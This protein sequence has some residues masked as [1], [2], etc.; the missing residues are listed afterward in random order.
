MI[1]FPNVSNFDCRFID[2]EIMV[3]ELNGTIRFYD[4]LTVRPLRTAFYRAPLPV[5]SDCINVRRLSFHIL[6]FRIQ[7]RMWLDE[8]DVTNITE[9]T[10]EVRLRQRE[11][12]DQYL[13]A[14][15]QA[16]PRVRRR[17]PLQG[18]SVVASGTVVRTRIERIIP[19]YTRSKW[20]DHPTGKSDIDKTSV[21]A[22]AAAATCRGSR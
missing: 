10:G 6:R 17:Q 3:V 13:P 19:N 11:R 22:S 20:S 12:F 5:R 2:N 14:R 4:V 7:L 9:L 21:L 8:R 15:R 1:F 16:S 18:H